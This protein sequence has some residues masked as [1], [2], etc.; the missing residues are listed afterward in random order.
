MQPVPVEKIYVVNKVMQTVDEYA[1]GHKPT[2]A[3]QASVKPFEASLKVIPKTGGRH[4]ELY[5]EEDGVTY[6]IHPSE[7]R[8]MIVKGAKIE[9]GAVSGV[10]GFA[11]VSTSITLRW[12]GNV[13]ERVSLI[14][15]MVKI[16]KQAREEQERVV[17]DHFGI[18]YKP[19]F[20][21][22]GTATLTDGRV[23]V[24]LRPVLRVEPKVEEKWVTEV[25]LEV[26]ARPKSLWS[27]HGTSAVKEKY[28]VHLGERNNALT[29]AIIR[30]RG[31]C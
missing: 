29:N 28:S 10:W 13:P 4:L 9:G 12:L 21:E 25:T 15:H 18:L 5:N 7:V 19:T 14:E 27:Y 2:A 31:V 26:D 3:R 24:T 17:K 11:R 23:K 30:L 8:R 22:D 1:W 16:A 6:K 20:K